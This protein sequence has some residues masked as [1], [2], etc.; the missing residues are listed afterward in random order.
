MADDT[1]APHQHI[2][3]WFIAVFALAYIS[4]YLIEF[5]Y[6][7]SLGIV[8]AAG[9]IFKLKYIQTGIMFLLSS[10]VIS[11]FIVAVFFAHRMRRGLSETDAPGPGVY[12]TW[13]SVLPALAYVFSLYISVILTPLHYVETS[14]QWIGI[15]L[16]V[17]LFMG[18]AFIFLGAEAYYKRLYN[19]HYS[20]VRDDTILALQRRWRFIIRARDFVA[21]VFLV[22]TVIADISFL[23]ERRDALL[24]LLVGGAWIYVLFTLLIPALL[25]RINARLRE[26]KERGGE[27]GQFLSYMTMTGGGTLLCF[28]LF[29][30]FMTYSYWVFP[31]IPSLKG[32]ADY[33]DASTVRMIRDSAPPKNKRPGLLASRGGSSKDDRDLEETLI[34]YSTESSYYL[35]KPKPDPK[36]EKSNTPCEWRAG[37][38]IPKITEI[39][40]DEIK[41]VLINAVPK[42]S[43]C[44]KKKAPQ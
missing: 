43:N 44:G 21:M 13:C 24:D 12:P 14:D 27:R 9:D 30:M 39:H 38:K 36:P 42:E 23:Y 37:R 33:E 11:V 32:G 16:L 2:P 18:Y 25:Y 3:P 5:L 40:R 6:Y 7:G 35:A 31:F 17:A 1:R 8:D 22:L 26:A 19:T 4:G 29:V 20:P 15:V 34:L 10:T 41:R 28:V